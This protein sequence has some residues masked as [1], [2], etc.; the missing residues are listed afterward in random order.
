LGAHI[1]P[2]TRGGL[3][4]GYEAR[5][6]VFD[7]ALART[8]A[9][10]K[11]RRQQCA[12]EC[13]LVVVR[14]DYHAVGNLIAEVFRLSIGVVAY[15]L[16]LNRSTIPLQTIEASLSGGGRAVDSARAKSNRLQVIGLSAAQH[17]DRQRNA[18]QRGRESFRIHR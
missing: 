1:K 13:V 7:G 12:A 15:R 16:Q 10:T 4:R 9:W 11:T 8:L 6:I 5:S 2:R 3:Y 17:A 18:S 14:V